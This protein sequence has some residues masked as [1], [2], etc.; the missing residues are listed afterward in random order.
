MKWQGVLPAIT[1]PFKPDF[2]V[3]AD[4][5]V[6]ELAELDPDVLAALLDR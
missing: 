3:D 4:L 5:L 1:T 6:R 2:S